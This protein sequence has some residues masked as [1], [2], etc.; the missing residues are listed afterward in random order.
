MHPILRD[1]RL[2][3]L[4]ALAAIPLLSWT[5]LGPVFGRLLGPSIGKLF[6][7][8]GIDNPKSYGRIH[9]YGDD[10]LLPISNYTSTFWESSHNLGTWVNLDCTILKHTTDVPVNERRIIVYFCGKRDIYQSSEKEVLRDMKATKADA[11][12]FNYRGGGNR[13]LSPAPKKFQE[14]VE[15]AK[16]VLR[17]LI[18]KGYKSNRMILKG[19]STGGPVLLAAAS[20]LLQEDKIKFGG[21]FADRPFSSITAVIHSLMK[22]F[23]HF[24]ILGFISDYVTYGIIS[25]LLRG[26]GWEANILD[27][28]KFLIESK[29]PV[30]LVNVH[31]Q[32]PSG[33]KDLGVAE[34][35][36]LNAIATPEKL[37]SDAFDV[38]ASVKDRSTG[39]GVAMSHL[40][41]LTADGKT[42]TANDY[43]D[44]FCSGIK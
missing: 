25:P 33:G 1:S 18:N 28:Y 9:E 31:A 2:I 41:R 34:G 40:E 30:A 35:S 37:L 6:V 38:A 12:M 7:S 11:F 23:L 43:F 27:S 29:M 13:P 16:H 14:M 42:E 36:L 19:H 17:E 10:E 20:Q 39:H 15:D 21:C 5:I 8:P 22:H 4:Y 3:P 24:R 44:S 32:D 26:S